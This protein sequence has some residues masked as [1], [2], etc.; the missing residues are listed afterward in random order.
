MA[1]RAGW[2]LMLVGLSAWS[3][4][5]AAACSCIKR[6]QACEVVFTSGPIFRGR[7]LSVDTV[8]RPPRPGMRGPYEMRR[9]TFAIAERLRGDLAAPQV[10]VLTGTGG[11]DCGYDFREEVEYL[12][13]TYAP[14]ADAP[15]E[16]GIC[17]RTSP[18]SGAVA[19]ADLAFLRALQAKPE[20]LE[21]RIFGRVV[22]EDPDFDDAYS[23]LRVAPPRA[24]VG[25]SLTG[26][27]G[28][29]RTRTDSAGAFE[30]VGL[31]V[32]A[33][34]LNVDLEEVY[35]GW[36]LPRKLEL[37]APQACVNVPVSVQYD[38]HVSGR[39]VDAAGAAVPG[40]TLELGSAR[41]ADDPRNYH[42]VATQSRG[43]GSF[44]LTQVPPGRYVLGI[45]TQF[46]SHA[47]RLP[48]PRLLFPGVRDAAQA[49]VVEVGPGERVRI[50]DFTLPADFV[51]APIAG[52][53]TMEDGTPVAGANVYLKGPEERDY[54]PLAGPAV[55][56]NAGR[57]TLAGMSGVRYRI[58][59]D[60]RTQIAKQWKFAASDDARV[61]TAAAGLP[62][63][64]IVMKDVTRAQ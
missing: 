27:G 32:G 31:G 24:G 2:M 38:G 39:I 4:R 54:R 35:V 42:R 28:A 7:A 57:F 19:Q 46:D 16:T 10:E 53:V 48:D 25:V 55:T 52:I 47:Q 22:F 36:Q 34:E 11:G 63:V 3:D 17:T 18:A 40:V 6:D 5:P 59:A 50:P 43:D 9:V 15:L 37:P 13:Y 14:R 29:R 44:E 26:N 23:G 20:S 21:S 41:R 62:P 51:M 61:F 8:S 33:Y 1:G 49:R 60:K 30:F 56:D 64:R 45:N 12:V 58:V